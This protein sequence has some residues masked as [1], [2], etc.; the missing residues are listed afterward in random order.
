MFKT[1]RTC[2]ICKRI[3]TTKLLT[4][5]FKVYFVSLETVDD[6][7]GDDVYDTTNKMIGQSKQEKL[8]MTMM[9]VTM[10]SVGLLPTTLPE[11][12]LTRDARCTDP[13]SQLI[14]TDKIV[15]KSG[16][17]LTIIF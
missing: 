1:K 7:C 9:M 4:G 8:L 10:V 5:D 3:F 16:N 11:M 13:R 12:F 17:T 6:D 15:F 2:K 14:C